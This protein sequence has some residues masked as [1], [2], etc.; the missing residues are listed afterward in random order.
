M[1]LSPVPDHV[2]HELVRDFDLLA[3]PGMDGNYTSDV[4]AIWKRVQDTMPS[5][6]W[7]PRNGGHWVLTRYNEI[8]E[9]A[10]DP[11]SYSS[12]QNQLPL[13][14]APPLLPVNAD[15]PEHGAYRKLLM[16]WFSPARLATA[17]ETARQTAI[18]VIDKLKPQGGCEFYEDFAG[19]M[20]VVTFLSLVNMPLSDLDYLRDVT[21]RMKVSD[22]RAPAAWVDLGQYVA[23]QIEIRRKNPQDDVLSSFHKAEVFGR[24]LTEKE[25]FDISILMVAGGLDTVLAATCFAAEFLARSPAHRHE[26]IQHP[27]RISNAIEELLRRFGVANLCRIATKDSTLGGVGIKDGDVVLALFPLAGLDETV[28]EDPMTVDFQRKGP[29]HLIFG[30]GPHVC[31][32]N[33]LAKREIKVFIEEWLQRIPDFSIAPGH[34]PKMVTGVTNNVEELQL[35]W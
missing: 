26:L 3:P 6:F 24:P 1:S 8:R 35:V 25:I 23:K 4:H 16:P 19:V 14:I 33:G 29:K 11:T 34:E 13:G 28:N 9:M 2:P 12:R 27:E 17:S 32:G 20:P 5:V 21:S 15:P 31:I 10:V 18:S 7:T 22:P 30:T